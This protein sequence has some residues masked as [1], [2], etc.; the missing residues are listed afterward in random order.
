MTKRGQENF[1][2]LLFMLKNERGE[3]MFYKLEARSHIKILAISKTPTH[4][5]LARQLYS[6]A[7]WPI[8]EYLKPIQYTSE[9]KEAL[10][11]SAIKIEQDLF[12]ALGV[13]SKILDPSAH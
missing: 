6:S 5:E 4:P 7:E 8:P 13:P 12:S 11:L 1:P 10:R 3:I 2:W 9:E